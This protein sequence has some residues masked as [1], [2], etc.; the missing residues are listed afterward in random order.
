MKWSQLAAMAEPHCCS[1]EGELCLVNGDDI[2]FIARR[3]KTSSTACWREFSGRGR[4][5]IAGTLVE[6]QLEY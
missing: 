5:A 3:S 1:L 4:Y 6:C 2:A